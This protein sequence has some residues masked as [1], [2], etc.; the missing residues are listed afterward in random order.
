MTVNSQQAENWFLST[1]LLLQLQGHGDRH[2]LLQA[3]SFDWMQSEGC[4]QKAVH[5]L[6]V[7]TTAQNFVH[8]DDVLISCSAPASMLSVSEL[9]AVE[10]L[11]LLSGNLL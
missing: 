5:D 11:M 6:C 1:M 8:D 4:S 10:H 7:T 9:H 2:S 3:T